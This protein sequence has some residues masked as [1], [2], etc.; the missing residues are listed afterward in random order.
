MEQYTHNLESVTKQ[1]ASIEVLNLI[2]HSYRGP[3]R[4][5]F[6]TDISSCAD[7]NRNTV[8]H[9]SQWKVHKWL[10]ASHTR[11]RHPY[12]YFSH[13]P[14]DLSSNHSSYRLPKFTL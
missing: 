3:Q 12:L 6:L 13:P 1:L 2:P 11:T 9:Q 14:C 8:I 5:T 4:G 7:I 10:N